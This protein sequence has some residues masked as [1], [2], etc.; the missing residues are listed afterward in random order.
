[1]K[2][3]YFIKNVYLLNYSITNIISSFFSI[4]YHIN[5]SV[6]LKVL[7]NINYVCV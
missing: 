4:F 7:T 3:Q 6:I 1:M 2:P 5:E